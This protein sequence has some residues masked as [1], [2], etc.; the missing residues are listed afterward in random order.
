MCVHNVMYAQLCPTLC[1]PTDCNLPGSSVHEIFQVKILE[2][3]A[4]SFSRGSSPP[5]DWTRVCCVSC[6]AGGFFTNVSPFNLCIVVNSDKYYGEKCSMGRRRKGFSTWLSGKESAC[7]WRRRGFD[8]WVRKIPWRRKWQPTPVFLPENPK[9]RGAWRA[10]VHRVTK[11][12]Y[13]T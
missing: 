11:E 3:V 12:L 1:D 6:I 8:P 5:R 4:I 10:A 7:Q 2:W 13:T 9:N